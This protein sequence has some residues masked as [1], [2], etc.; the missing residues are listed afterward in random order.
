M[1]YRR[2]RCG[3]HHS[4]PHRPSAA[5]LTYVREYALANPMHHRVVVTITHVLVGTQIRVSTLDNNSKPSYFDWEVLKEHVSVVFTDE[6]DLGLNIQLVLQ[7][8]FYVA[9]QY[10]FQ[11]NTF[12]VVC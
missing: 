10:S 1:F 9:L 4:A 6:Q 3:T 8:V 11:L 12:L 7:N 2:L 5:A